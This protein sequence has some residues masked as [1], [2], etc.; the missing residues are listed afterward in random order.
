MFTAWKTSFWF[1]RALNYTAMSYWLTLDLSEIFN[2]VS[3]TFNFLQSSK[4][5]I[6]EKVSQWSVSVHLRRVIPVCQYILWEPSPSLHSIALQWASSCL[7]GIY[8]E[9]LLGFYHRV[10][11]FYEN[12]WKPWVFK[13]G[14]K[15]FPFFP[16]ITRLVE[17]E[18]VLVTMV[19]E[20][21]NIKIFHVSGKQLRY[22]GMY[23]RKEM[24]GG[25][26][27][28]QK[29]RENALKTFWHLEPS[30]LTSRF[31]KKR[32]HWCWK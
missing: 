5:C 12:K 21:E 24:F 10:Q 13:A 27:R 23:L 16:A 28:L 1:L 18:E 14:S 9:R 20:L 29:F 15:P 32:K 11:V 17:M 30:L 7:V 19:K 4:D 2:I 6:P 25:A 8:L 3:K 26:Q 31:W 22:F